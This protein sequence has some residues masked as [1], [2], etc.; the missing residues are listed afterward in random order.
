MSFNTIY[1]YIILKHYLKPFLRPLSFNTI[2]LY[3][4]LKH[5]TTHANAESVLIPYIFTSFSNAEFDL[6]V[7][8]EF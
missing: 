2:Y 4:I 1:L 8:K 3:I 5:A 6:N 7:L